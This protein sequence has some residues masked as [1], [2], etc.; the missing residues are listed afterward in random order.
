MWHPEWLTSSSAA[1]VEPLILCGITRSHLSATQEGKKSVAGQQQTWNQFKL[2]QLL[3]LTLL[4]LITRL[5]TGPIQCS[6]TSSSSASV[7]LLKGLKWN[8][9]VSTSVQAWD[10]LPLSHLICCLVFC[11]LFCFFQRWRG[12]VLCN[13]VSEQYWWRTGFLNWRKRSERY[14]DGLQ[15]QH[16]TLGEQMPSCHSK[17]VTPGPA[18][19]LLLCL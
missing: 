13:V 15:L 19:I 12:N 8:T 7:I 11:F 1:W 5:W 3:C 6:C 14:E 17:W 2:A 10:M 4:I 18:D 16:V 9:Y